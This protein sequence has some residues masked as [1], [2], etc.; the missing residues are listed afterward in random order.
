M[1]KRIHSFV[2]SFSSPAYLAIFLYFVRKIFRKMAPPAIERPGRYAV[3]LT[4]TPTSLLVGSFDELDNAEE[5]LSALTDEGWGSDNILYDVKSGTALQG[6][7]DCP[8]WRQY[9]IVSVFAV[10]PAQFGGNEDSLREIR[11]IASTRGQTRASTSYPGMPG[12]P[13]L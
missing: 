12:V 4:T 10:T 9:K 7:A 1:V 6:E 5:L 3:I 13:T 8:I 11:S 2:T